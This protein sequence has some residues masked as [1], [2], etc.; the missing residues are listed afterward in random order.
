MR[1][2]MCIFDSRAGSI[3]SSLYCHCTKYTMK[4]AEL[5]LKQNK[6]NLTCQ[7]DGTRIETVFKIFACDFK[8][9]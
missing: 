6:T 8:V 5:H 1:Q 7:S 2:L 4:F 3:Q 9:L